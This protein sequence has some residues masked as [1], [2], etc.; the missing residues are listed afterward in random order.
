MLLKAS[1]KIAENKATPG[2]QPLLCGLEYEMPFLDGL[3]CKGKSKDNKSKALGLH[4]TNARP[5][6]QNKV[7]VF[8]FVRFYNTPCTPIK[9]KR[10]KA[11]TS[12]CKRSKYKLN[13]IQPV[14]TRPRF[15]PCLFCL[16]P[17]L[18]S[19]LLHT[20]SS[21][22][23]PHT[24]FSPFLLFQPPLHPLVVFTFSVSFASLWIR[25]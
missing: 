22:P 10:P 25:L 6:E 16:S 12:Y 5:I 7:G 18:L 3:G 13:G 20:D 21:L 23:D 2:Y 19:P 8:V 4:R 15:P 11:S 24:S 14:R 1:L 17:L 9:P